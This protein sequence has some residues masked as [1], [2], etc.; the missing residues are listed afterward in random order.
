[1]FV[2]INCSKQYIS[3]I[4]HKKDIIC[5]RAVNA[6]FTTKTETTV[7][8]KAETGVLYAF[9]KISFVHLINSVMKMEEICRSNLF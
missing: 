3:I 1:M 9:D 7:T 5:E 6:S 2:S 4:K 8:K